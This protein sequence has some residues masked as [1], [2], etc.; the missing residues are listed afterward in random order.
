MCMQSDETVAHP[1]YISLPVCPVLTYV[2]LQL[3]AIGPN[4]KDD[5]WL[6]LPYVNTIFCSEVCAIG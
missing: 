2:A 4:M 3:Y 5:L 6:Q 1:V